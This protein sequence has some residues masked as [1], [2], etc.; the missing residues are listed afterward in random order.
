MQGHSNVRSS[1][2]RHD[3][4]I[5]TGACVKILFLAVNISLPSV[6]TAVNLRIERRCPHI[7]T[8]GFRTLE[9]YAVSPREST[10]RVDFYPFAYKG[11]SG[12][13]STCVQVLL[14]AEE[15]P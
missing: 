1:S 15:F 11:E 12:H 3:L 6:K 9:F 10:C 13:K 8:A 14:C 4:K 5:F 2:I 7:D